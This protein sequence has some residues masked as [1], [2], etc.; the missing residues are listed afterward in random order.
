M[1]ACQRDLSPVPPDEKYP[2]I[3]LL[4]QSYTVGGV[5]MARAAG[6][7][8]LTRDEDFTACIPTRMPPKG[9]PTRRIS[10]LEALEIAEEFYKSQRAHAR[11]AEYCRMRRERS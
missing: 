4:E 2:G 9:A 8:L 7:N 5:I 6:V 11:N 1:P 10:I 3:P